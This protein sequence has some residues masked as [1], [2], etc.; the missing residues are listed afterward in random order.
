MKHTLTAVALV[1]LLAA[2]SSM[3]TGNGT[4][5]SDPIANQKLSTSFVSEGIKIETK[6]SWFGMG[7]DCKIVAIESV[8]TAPSF[9]NTD[10]N[11]RNALTRA[12]MRAN[13]NVAEFLNKE[14]TTNR[15]NN[16]I[17]KNI[18]K[19]T[20]KVNSGKADDK[21]V[22]MTDKE[23]SNISLRENTNDTVVQLTETIRTNSSA[24]LKGFRKLDKDGER[25]VGPQVVAVTIRWDLESNASRKQLLKSM[26]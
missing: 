25:V 7:S 23:A 19:A 24:I 14:I 21:T 2:C 22:E 12:E 17:A 15:V 4:N 9:G 18:E 5:S 11:F 1:S 3:K 10:S 16:T 20:D 13:A 26:Q 8:G 6:C